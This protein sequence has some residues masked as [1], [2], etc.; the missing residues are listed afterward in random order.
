[1]T[2]QKKAVIYAL[3]AC[4]VW[5]SVY[6]AIKVGINHGLKPLTFAGVRFL[7]G[8]AIL[9]A[10]AWGMGR[11]K[12]SPR[13][14]WVLGAFG[15]FQ[16]GVQ[17]ALFFKGVQLT[18]AGISAIFINTSPFFVILFAPIFFRASRITPG[19]IIGTLI[20]FGGVLLASWDSRMPEGG[21]ELGILF[22]ILSAITWAGSNIAA[23]KIMETRDTLT[24]TGAQMALGAL[25]LIGAGCLTEGRFMAGVDG[26]GIAA[27]LY[28]VVFATSIPFLAWYKA[29]RLGEVG[30]VS[31][32]GFT[33]P[34]LGVVSG[35][36]LLG[37]PMSAQIL[38]GMTM[39]AFGIIVVNL[40]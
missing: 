21:Y 14:L 18:N 26:A 25:P 37:E 40:R 10:I 6:V 2:D 1:M 12:L 11:L 24:V 29:L 35:W 5:G 20:G 28:L 33:L 7:A 22:L 27:L 32:F 3:I 13:D 19:R 8:G 15:V 16:T 34:I 39:V 30:K 17:N 4:L 36:L 31:V 23:K 38:V 9:L